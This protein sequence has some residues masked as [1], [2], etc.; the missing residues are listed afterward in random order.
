MTPNA[1]SITVPDEDYQGRE[2]CLGSNE[3][4]LSISDVSDKDNPVAIAKEEYPAVVYAHQ[5]WLTEDHRFF[6]M[7]DEGDEPTGQVEGTRT[8]IWD[9]EDLDEPMMVKEYIAATTDTDHNLYIVGNLMYQSNYGAGLRVLDISN[10]TDPVEVA[11]LDIA[12]FS[13]ASWSNYPFFE[14]GVVVMTSTGSGLFIV[15][16]TGRRNLIP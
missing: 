5:G 13:G 14:S 11:F 6:Y 2:V 12:P 3:T 10:P 8:L 16:N 7:N 9:L 15:R 4:H 1:S